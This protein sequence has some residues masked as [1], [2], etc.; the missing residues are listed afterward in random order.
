M[1]RAGWVGLGVFLAV[2]TAAAIPASAQIPKIVS[3]GSLGAVSWWDGYYAIIFNTDAMTIDVYTSA[4]GYN[5]GGAC[6]IAP[7]PNGCARLVTQPGGSDI[8]VW[9]FT[10][11][12][13]SSGFYVRGSRPA[14]IAASGTITIS[15]TVLV[16]NGFAGAPSPATCPGGGT[17]C[18]AGI[19]GG[20]PGGGGGGAGPGYY[21]TVHEGGFD[22]YEPLA[23]GGGAGGGG[24]ANGAKGGDSRTLVDVYGTPHMLPGGTAGAGYLSG[25]GP[26][27]G[28]SGG[29]SGGDRPMW[30]GPQT[31]GGA[32]GGYGG[33][34][35]ILAAAGD[36]VVSGTVSAA[37]KPG[38]GIRDGGGGGGGGGGYVV[39]QVAGQLSIPAGATVSAAGGLGGPGPGNQMGDSYGGRGGGGFVRIEAGSVS[40]AGTVD[41]S[42]ANPGALLF[43]L[44]VSAIGAGSGVVTSDPGS[45][46][47][48]A[49]SGVVG[50]DC[51]AFFASGENV[52][53]AATA[54]TGSRFV[55][56]SGNCS[57]G[58][59][60]VSSPM[61]CTAEFEPAARYQL[62]TAVVP[63]A[64]GS[65]TVSPTS[66][67]GFYFE[68]T[69]IQLPAVPGS[70]F[71]FAG[72]SGDLTGTE[73]PQSI[74]MNAAR[75]VTANFTAL[76][77]PDFKLGPDSKRGNTAAT[78]RAGSTATYRLA[79]SGLGGFAA[80]ITLSCSDEVALSSCSPS[81]AQVV[82]GA[83]GVARFTMAVTT[84]GSSRKNPSSATPPGT[85]TVFVT[86]TSGELIRTLPL[87]LT[88]K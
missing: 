88:V 68:S 57:S 8:V 52:T 18:G 16:E 19:A 12:S 51:T 22:V 2:L 60:T 25:F 49:S 15:G 48:V 46:N 54:S 76:Q 11:V 34:A 50:G 56:W 36:I 10:S 39:F 42:G 44:T 85:Y 7:G 29:G 41:V 87:T 37:G 67:D 79:A 23:G 53:L 45:L 4:G 33:G 74:T 63:A 59:V 6:P 55:G 38:D 58:A 31:Y 71:T 69:E 13:V 40:I 70:G 43:P 47:C 83:T 21:V 66:A 61:T 64:G 5:V 24:A 78:V 9:D 32:S 86:G 35:L 30:G 65:V 26:L 73:N 20:G 1:R 75:S 81:P 62:T 3:N 82:I 28:G 84:T 80:S 14:A 17:G 77:P 72:W 27:V